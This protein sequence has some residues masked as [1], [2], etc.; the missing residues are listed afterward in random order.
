[1]YLCPITHLSAFIQI[2]DYLK[3]DTQQNC[4]VQYRLPLP[5]RTAAW[6]RYNIRRI[7]G[8][9]EFRIKAGEFKWMRFMLL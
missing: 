3:A 1:V 9:V 2:S 5:Q 4:F 6:L 8:F 7:K